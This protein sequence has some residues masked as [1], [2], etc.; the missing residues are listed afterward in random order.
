ME[1]AAAEVVGGAPVVA[2]EPVAGLVEDRL[3]AVTAGAAVKGWARVVVGLPPVVGGAA[4]G[5]AMA[6]T[7][8]GE[9]GGVPVAPAMFVAPNTHASMLPAGGL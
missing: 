3:T 6:R 4:G 2:V 8:P 5:A 1:G 9:N 7:W